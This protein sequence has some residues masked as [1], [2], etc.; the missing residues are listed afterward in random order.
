ME[1]CIKCRRIKRSFNKPAGQDIL[2]NTFLAVETYLY[3]CIDVHDNHSTYIPP[4]EECLNTE[5]RHK[6]GGPWSLL[7]TPAFTDKISLI[8]THNLA[9]RRKTGKDRFGMVQ[10]MV[11]ERPQWPRKDEYGPWRTRMGQKGPWPIL[12]QRDGQGKDHYPGY[13]GWPRMVH[14]R[15]VR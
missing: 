4:Q 3:T 13:K 7:N 11:Q 15:T 9:R 12:A 10:R 6:R 1:E 8:S 2:Y 5:S 14:P